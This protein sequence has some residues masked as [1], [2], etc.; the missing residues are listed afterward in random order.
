MSSPKKVSKAPQPSVRESEAKS[1]IIPSKQSQISLKVQKSPSREP[2]SKPITPSNVPITKEMKSP[3]KPGAPPS[4][5]KDPQPPT[6]N[7]KS[8][9]TPT[10]VSPSPQINPH[11][12][13]EIKI[14]SRKRLLETLEEQTPFCTD[15]MLLQLSSRDAVIEELNKEL[16]QLK[17][18]L[19]EQ[20]KAREQ[21]ESQKPQ[22]DLQRISE[23]ES[24]KHQLENKVTVLVDRHRN[25]LQKLE[26]EKTQYEL[27]QETMTEEIDLLRTQ[28]RS[29]EEEIGS[30]VG[31]IRKLSEI[32]QQ[33]K[34]LNLELNQKVEKQN[35]EFEMMSNKFYETEVKASSLEELENNLQDYIRIYQQSESRSNRLAEE[36]RNMQVMYSDLQGFCSY[37]EETLE[38]FMK[39]NGREGPLVETV[40]KIKVELGQRARIE[41]AEV[42]ENAKDVK[43]RELTQML[44]K[45]NREF[46]LLETSQKPLVDQV[47]GMAQILSTLKI[48]HTNSIDNLNKTLKAVQDQSDSVKTEVQQLRIESSKKDIKITSLTHKLSS[49]ENKLTTAEDK[50]KKLNDIKNAL[51]KDCADHKLRVATIKLQNTER[52]SQISALE[53]QNS[54]YIVNIQALHEEFWK[55]DT[56]LIKAKKAVLRMQKTMGDIISHTNKS[57]VAKPTDH[58]EK[59]MKELYEK[60]QKIE[61]LK[62][63]VKASQGKNGKKGEGLSPD[64]SMQEINHD[65]M[66]KSNGDLVNSLAA[67]T[68][69]KFFTICSFHR[70]SPQDSP[71]DYQRLLK[72][73]KQD[74]KSYKVFSTKDMMASVP[75]LQHSLNEAKAHIG[76]DELLVIISKAIST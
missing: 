32:I 73:L 67:K 35:A 41:V 66:K 62:E 17:A 44:E 4:N 50:I 11:E 7:T 12:E 54:K 55:K 16:I 65:K 49:S 22:Q 72:K 60:E 21:E 48:E 33:F 57:G 23:L 56:A 43:I 63:M 6:K 51:E 3:S 31:D 39:V 40:Q 52:V 19:R 25:E 71:P 2:P 14:K 61:I 15:E 53:K 47:Q 37:S 75:Q 20:L 29:K 45:R 74:L 38:E 27:L 24:E 5:P 42:D 34:Q 69:N 46:A 58:Y 18:K 30:V 28:L 9:S 13:I 76:L 59:L 68:I 26:E 36:L 1:N 8:S 64:Q 10:K 70:N